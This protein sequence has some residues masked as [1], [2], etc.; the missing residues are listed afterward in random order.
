MTVDALI[1]RLGELRGQH[2][3]SCSVCVDTQELSGTEDSPIVEVKSVSLECVFM[4][5]GD[6]FVVKNRDGSERSRFCLVLK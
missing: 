6:G 5:D 3:G 4:A 2:G 1:K